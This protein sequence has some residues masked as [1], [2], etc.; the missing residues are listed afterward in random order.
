VSEGFYWNSKTWQIIPI[1]KKGDTLPGQSG[2]M[3]VHLNPLEMVITVLF[4]SG[5]FVLFLP[6]LGFQLF[7]YFVATWILGFIGQKIMSKIVWRLCRS[8][9]RLCHLIHRYL[10]GQCG[11]TFVDDPHENIRMGALGLLFAVIILAFVWAAIRFGV[12]RS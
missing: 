10:W 12:V 6:L 8:E 2:L 7:G 11:K 5:A 9:S 4:T 3:Y 1:P